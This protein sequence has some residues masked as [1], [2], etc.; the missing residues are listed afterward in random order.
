V[1]I[2]AVGRPIAFTADAQNWLCRTYILFVLGNVYVPPNRLVTLLR[3]AVAYQIQFSRYHP[4]IAPAV[5]SHVSSSIF[6]H[7]DI[8][9]VVNHGTFIDYY[10]IIPALSF[11]TL[12]V[13]RCVAMKEMSNVFG[14]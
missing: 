2:E 6:Q 7:S 11:L 12:F 9:T 4:K 1:L 3:Q 13:T 14:L 10:K 5:N 8:V